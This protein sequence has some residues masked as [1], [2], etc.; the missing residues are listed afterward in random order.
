MYYGEK[1]NKRNLV[2]TKFFQKKKLIEMPDSASCFIIS[3][4]KWSHQ[5][6]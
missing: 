6:F 1:L 5:I 2:K 3:G 4:L